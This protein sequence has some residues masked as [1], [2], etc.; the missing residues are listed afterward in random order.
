MNKKKIICELIYLGGVRE[1]RT[2]QKSWS[3]QMEQELFEN[4]CL[5][6]DWISYI[7][8]S[9][10]QININNSS[11][12][13]TYDISDDIVNKFENAKDNS[14]EPNDKVNLLM[15]QTI[16][17]IKFLLKHKPKKY[18]QIVMYLFKAFHNLPK[19]YFKGESGYFWEILPEASEKEVIDWYNGYIESAKKASLNI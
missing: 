7:T 1:K 19:V 15:L 12:K 14:F 6:E 17:Q 9:D 4:V 18:R 13:K 3:K 11:I 5:L 16:L 8:F 2:Q 10:F